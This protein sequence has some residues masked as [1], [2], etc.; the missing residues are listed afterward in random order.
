[1]EKVYQNIYIYSYANLYVCTNRD[2]VLKTVC[3]SC[4]IVSVIIHARFHIASCIS[5]KA[6]A[7]LRYYSFYFLSGFRNVI[8][9][10]ENVNEKNGTCFFTCTTLIITLIIQCR[11]SQL[12]LSTLL[13]L[14]SHASLS[15]LLELKTPRHLFCFITKYIFLCV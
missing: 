2:Y 10:D 4:D 1:M 12:V 9:K 13:F 11:L 3:T 8:K 15:F 6:R 7:C 5:R 14:S